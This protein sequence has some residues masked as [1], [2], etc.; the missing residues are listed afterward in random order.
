M[1]ILSLNLRHGGASRVSGICSYLHSADADVLVL[2]EFRRN[3]AG[4][5]I[6][7][8][9]KAAGYD[10]VHQLRSEPKENSVVILTRRRSKPVKLAPAPVDARR[11]VACDI[12]GLVIA[13]VYFTQQ[14]AKAS[15]FDF[16]LA[17]PPELDNALVIGDFN[18]GRHH[19]DEAGATFHCADRFTRLEERG[20]RD[21]WRAQWG[22]EA[23]EFSW[24]SPRGG[25][26]RI[27]YAFAT[28]G[29]VK[30]VT[31]CRYDHGTRP[32]IT[33]HSAMIVELAA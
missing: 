10:T 13:G 18:A 19:A 12:E 2:T 4:E 20:Y 6:V 33:D 23:R 31:D 32:R 27:D 24:V 28:E 25:G 9:M 22:Q 30:R 21:L 1:R 11:I 5:V 29:V 26:F 14:K 15:L 16:L 7:G 3:R 17:A 8:A